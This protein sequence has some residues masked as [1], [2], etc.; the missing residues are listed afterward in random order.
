MS[1][2]LPPLT[3][4]FWISFTFSP[5]SAAVPLCQLLW[6]AYMT[7]QLTVNYTNYSCDSGRAC[8]WASRCSNIQPHHQEEAIQKKQD[9]TTMNHLKKN[10]HHGSSNNTININASPTPA[11]HTLHTKRPPRN[12]FEKKYGKTKTTGKS[13]IPPAFHGCT[14]PM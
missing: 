3:I 6:C 2:H 7:S 5:S 12:C 11:T 9:E 1:F 8:H 10:T 4:C 13:S 14:E